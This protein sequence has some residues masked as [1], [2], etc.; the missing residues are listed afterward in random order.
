MQS[1]AR[2]CALALACGSA[3]ATLRN[4]DRPPMGF[5]PCNNV[6]CDM[7]SLGETE[8][9]ALA[10]AI[11]SNGMLAAGYTYFNLDDGWA[12]NR[13]PNGTITAVTP[14]FPSGTLAPLASYIASLGLS[15]GVYTDRGTTTCEGRP[16]SS[17]YEALD[18]ATYA[19]WGIKYVKEDSCA[20]PQDFPSAIAEYGAMAAALAAAGDIFFSLCGWSDYAARFGEFSPPIGDSWRVSTDVPN[21]DRFM[22]NLG[23]AAAVSA[24]TGPGRCVE[25]VAQEGSHRR[26]RSTRR[27]RVHAGGG[28]TST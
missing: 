4:R 14:A 25:W 6:G 15:L 10:Q 18:A 3:F 28:P 19:A 11:S 1:S 24:F 27:M 2:L 12:G 20:S 8:L 7:S 23:S 22:Q 13:L 9:R 5:N 16:G 17:G 26:G 21:W